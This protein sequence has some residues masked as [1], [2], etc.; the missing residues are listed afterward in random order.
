MDRPTSCVTGLLNLTKLCDP[1]LM[2]IRSK[3][4]NEQNNLKL[5]INKKDGLWVK[6]EIIML[7]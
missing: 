3:L 7:S 6:T 5:N 4:T 2:F 1:Q